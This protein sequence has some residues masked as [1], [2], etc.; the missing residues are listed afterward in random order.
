MTQKTTSEGGSNSYYGLFG[1]SLPITREEMSVMISRLLK[2]VSPEFTPNTAGSYLFTDED[3]I[4]GWALESVKF[5]YKNGI[6]NG[7]DGGRPFPEE[8]RDEL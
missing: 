5:C 4:A 7:V 1:P 8:I 3:K 6:I 2:A